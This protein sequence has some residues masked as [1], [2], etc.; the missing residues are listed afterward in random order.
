MEHTQRT[1]LFSI[2]A[3]ACLILAVVLF[4]VMGSGKFDRSVSLRTLVAKGSPVVCTYTRTTNGVSTD[5][6][7]YVAGGMARGT[8]TSHNANTSSIQNYL[9]VKDGAQYM[10]SSALS[11][12][13]KV[14]TDSQNKS[15][16]NEPSVDYDATA[17]YVCKSWT[18]D[19]QLFA[20]PVGIDFSS[21]SNTSGTGVVKK[22]SK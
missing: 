22:A 19:M 18:P 15:S 13:V 9:L 8:F 6:V 2:G 11:Y 4:V 5:A 3:A 17:P 12:G 14:P 21:T 16:A 1:S 20:L 10:W 7:V